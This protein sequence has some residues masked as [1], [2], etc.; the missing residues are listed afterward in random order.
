MKRIPK[1]LKNI[2]GSMRDILSTSKTDAALGERNLLLCHWQKKEQLCVLHRAANG[3]TQ[4]IDCSSREVL[5]EGVERVGRALTVAILPKSEYLVKVI[6]TP[7]VPT[8]EVFAMLRLEIEATLP[9]DTAEV[10]ISYLQL[11]P[12]EGKEGRS[13]F[14]VYIARD[15]TLQ[16]LT[17]AMR[18]MGLEPDMILPSV[19]AWRGVFADQT[20]TNMLVVEL[21]DDEIETAVSQSDGGCHVR[22][23]ETSS[24]DRQATLPP[25]VLESI[26]SLL[27]HADPDQ[28]QDIAWCGDRELPIDVG[29]I[30]QFRH[31]QKEFAN[32]TP[33]I[34]MLQLV[35]SG[36]GHISTMAMATSGLH[37]Q[38]QEELRRRTLIM[39]RFAIGAAALFLGLVLIQT[40]IE[41]MIYRSEQVGLEFSERISHIQREGET[42]ENRLTQLK[43]VAAAKERQNDF[44]DLLETLYEFTPGGISYS[45]ISM[46][47]EGQISVRGQALSMGEPFLLPNALDGRGPLTRVVV[48]SAQLS[49]TSRGT[50]TEFKADMSLK[51]R[52][53]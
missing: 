26:R 7:Q 48:R 8:Q 33:G 14:E 46:N 5:S 2:A 49:T 36:L 12:S 13:K 21:P 28:I 24:L 39:R 10:D 50:I 44:Q 45:E 30:V 23:I 11:P 27:A 40:A 51:R 34:A 42:S 37:L 38:G 31:T 29:S 4:P 1:W 17:N 43:A 15:E 53:Q 25:G 18:G 41:I 47:D 52:G 35:S 32:E 3:E 20:E 19:V 9:P 6:E 16:R 22:T